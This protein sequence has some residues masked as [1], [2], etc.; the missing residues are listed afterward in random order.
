MAPRC[1]VPICRVVPKW[2]LVPQ[3][4]MQIFGKKIPSTDLR[5]WDSGRGNL[6]VEYDLRVGEN[7]TGSL[8]E[9]RKGAC[10]AASEWGESH[11]GTNNIESN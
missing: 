4:Y 3:R 8:L 2:V 5:N 1:L 6:V 9:G 10:V 7:P 11:L